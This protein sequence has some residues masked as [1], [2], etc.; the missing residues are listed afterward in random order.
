MSQNENKQF[1]RQYK[2]SHLD[3][4]ELRKR[5]EDN[6]IML[7]K[8][9]RD[10]QLLKKRN[11]DMPN[12]EDSDGGSNIQ[13]LNSMNQNTVITQE[14]I[15]LLMYGNEEQQLNVTQ[16]FRKLLSKEPNPPIDEVIST[17]IVPKFV[18]FLQRDDYNLQFEAAWA[19]TNI[20]SGNSLQTRCV[21]D[22]GALAIF[23]KLLSSPY[24]DV[25]EQAVW[26]LGNIAGD[27]PECRELVLD[28]GILPP[29][30]EILSKPTS[31]LTMTRNAVWCL[32]NLCRG[33]NPPVDFN[34]VEPAL[35]ILST[36][37]FNQDVDV[38]ADACWAIS[39]LS[40]GPNEKIQKIIEANVCRR[41]VE[42]LMHGSL[43]VVQAALRAVGNIVT[44]D[45][46][47]TQVILNCNAL[48]CLLPLLNST[49]E[50]IRKEACWT[51]SNITAGNRG[52]IQ[53]VFNANIFP[54]LIEIL[55]KGENKTRKEAAWAIVN[56][57]SS[58]TQEQ[59][60]YLVELNVISPLCDLLQTIDTKVIEV[61][62]NG[63]DNI[64]KLGLHDARVNGGNNPYAI[65]IEECSG[66][67]K[68]E[69]L[70]G[71]QN[72]KIY[73]KAFQL[74]ENYFSQE[75]EDT[76]LMPQVDEKNQQF[77]FNVPNQLNISNSQSDA[78][79]QPT[80]SSAMDG[81]PATAPNTG[82]F[83]QTPAFNF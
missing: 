1:R 36:L 11:V 14:M 10:E 71:H 20:A 26:A 23:V 4:D 61:A 79:S 44:G 63:L 18:E 3:A 51:I 57:T 29:L 24:E 68:I 77:E 6:T 39:Y 45:D 53:A 8:Q 74:I 16:R 2:Y 81:N 69:F 41:L 35:P 54:K 64:L 13:D 22:A 65:K 72:E 58:G 66:L 5:R 83:G 55:A 67:D 37:L 56:A 27:S 48:S 70:Q 76:G 60:R 75:E 17:G 34:K 62:L 42:L 32:S 46:S 73:K 78:S 7:R 38:L 59:I 9:K 43:N 40:D 47:Q 25:Q 82:A 50:S 80:T 30:I 28:H 15:Q 31:R 33:K 21:I 19:L 52:Q 12:D 49:K